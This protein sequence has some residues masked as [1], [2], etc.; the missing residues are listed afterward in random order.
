MMIIVIKKLK[1]IKKINF[2]NAKKKRGLGGDEK[3]K[4]VNIMNSV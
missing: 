3:H 1:K 2:F 4:Y